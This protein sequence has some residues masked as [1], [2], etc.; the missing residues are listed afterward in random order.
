MKLYFK[1]EIMD[2]SAYKCT[3]DLNDDISMYYYDRNN[4]IPN[5]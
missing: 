4:M 5:T 3:N 2:L 1:D